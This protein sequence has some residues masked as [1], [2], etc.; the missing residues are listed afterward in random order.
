MNEEGLGQVNVGQVI[1]EEGL[2]QVIVGQV[3]VLFALSHEAGRTRNTRL[4][5]CRPS[6]G[7]AGETGARAG[8]AKGARRGA[9]REPTAGGP[10]GFAAGAT[11]ECLVAE[12]ALREYREMPGPGRAGTKA[13]NPESTVPWPPP[14]SSGARSEMRPVGGARGVGPEAERSIM[15][16]LRSTVDLSNSLSSWS[17]ERC[18]RLLCA[19]KLLAGCCCC[20]GSRDLPP[21]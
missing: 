8:V 1:D 13:E 9:T 17:S 21:T 19:E 18:S 16:M 12:R 4:L 20:E 11:A 7:R 6:H 14:A 10:A 3:I 5:G 2:G 15:R